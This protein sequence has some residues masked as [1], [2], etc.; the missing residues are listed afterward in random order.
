M[1]NVAIVKKKKRKPSLID[2]VVDA[3]PVEMHYP[4]YEFLGPG[5]HLMKRLSKGQ[6]GVNLLDQGALKHDLAY[7]NNENR[8]VADEELMNLALTRLYAEDAESDEKIAAVLTACCIVSKLSL[9]K[10]C[11]KVKKVFNRKSGKKKIF[12][13]NAERKRKEK[14]EG[15]KKTKKTE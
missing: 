2:S 5:T 15:P 4:N 10:F 8:R 11:S 3:W 1:D 7:F 9:E 6:T 13:K 14:K 12:K